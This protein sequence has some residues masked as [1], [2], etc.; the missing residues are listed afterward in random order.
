MK[1]QKPSA[2]EN[3]TCPGPCD[4]ERGFLEV[5]VLCWLRKRFLPDSAFPNHDSV[6]FC[7]YTLPGVYVCYWW[8]SQFCP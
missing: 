5:F 7:P 8:H 3:L 4:A 1:A 6:K 2:L